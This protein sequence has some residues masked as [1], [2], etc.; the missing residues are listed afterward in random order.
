[1]RNGGIE[2]AVADYLERLDT[3]RGLSGHTVDA[4]RTDLTQFTT[5]CH[6]L[7]VERLDGVERRTVRRFLSQLT[8]LHYSRRSV[9]RKASAVRAFLEDAARRGEIPSNPAS[10]CHNRNGREHFRSRFLRQH[11]RDSSTIS[12]EP[13]PSIFEIEHC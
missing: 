9:A 4:Y 1:M 5:M 8:T 3:E 11:W 6:R 10:G 2:A 12:M 13:T 7:G